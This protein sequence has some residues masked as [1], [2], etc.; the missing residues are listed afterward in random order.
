M[1][2]MDGEN[3]LT[4][5]ELAQKVC[6]AISNYDNDFKPCIERSCPAAANCRHGHNGMIDW[7]RKVVGND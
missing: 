1:V 4:L 7:L 6:N 5:E 2:I 3:V